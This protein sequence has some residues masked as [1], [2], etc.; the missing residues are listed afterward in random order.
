MRKEL[1]ARALGGLLLASLIGIYAGFS[2]LYPV[3]AQSAPGKAAGSVSGV[4]AS[5]PGSVPES[6]GTGAVPEAAGSG[7]TRSSGNLMPLA[8][9]GPETIADLVETVSPSVVNIVSTGSGQRQ[10]QPTRGRS[11]EDGVRRI[12]RQYGVD[13]QSA[14]N[15]VRTTGAGVLITTDGF[16]L[17]SLHVVR[18]AETIKVSLKDGRSFDA[19]VIGRDGFSDL[20]VLKIDSFGLPTVK[21]GNPDKLRVGQWVFA[22]GNPFAYE[23]SVSAGL[24]SGLRREARSFTPA[25]GARTGALTFIQTDVPLNPGSSGGPL[26]NL[27]GEVIGINSFVRDEAQNIGFAI[28]ADTAKRI[29]QELMERGSAPH[30]Y[31]GVEMRDPSEQMSGP[32]LVNGVEITKVKIP[33]PAEK[34]GLL[35]GDLILEL[36]TKAVKSP[37]DVSR[38]IS[39]HALG[40]KVSMK[41]NRSGEDKTLSIRVEGLPEEFD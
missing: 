32:G 18:N 2:G 14:S 27:Y 26:F 34:A 30:P 4:A 6:A 17:T 20:S 36:D 31:L 21:F 25:F 38:I 15:Q 7:S 9:F 39:S 29:A 23:S 5:G 40:D 10:E 12:R 22:I 8:G 28:P 35:V 33:S 11:Q 16:I 3:R 37:S 41:I 24:V 19:K 1:R 13:G